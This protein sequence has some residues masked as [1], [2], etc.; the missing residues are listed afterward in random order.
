MKQ[1]NVSAI[2]IFCS[3]GPHFLERHILFAEHQLGLKFD[4]KTIL[5]PVFGGASVLARKE[6]F[7]HENN[8]AL[9]GLLSSFHKYRHS[10]RKIVLVNHENCEHTRLSEQ[11]SKE[12]LQ[13]AVENIKAELPAGSA[14]PIELWYA[15]LEIKGNPASGL[16][17]QK[18]ELAFFAEK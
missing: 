15:H 12:D 14:T 4:Q 3:S 8:I 11:E 13:K 5:I 2:M 6:T 17:F 10:L 18:V 16:V 9:R 7:E 1:S